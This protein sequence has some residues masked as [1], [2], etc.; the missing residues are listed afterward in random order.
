L[1]RLNVNVNV[2]ISLG[3]V[4]DAI[5]LTREVLM[6]RV[7]LI[8]FAGAPWTTMCYMVQGT[9][10]KSI[11]WKAKLW[12]Y[13]YPNA[14]HKLLRIITDI[15]VEYLIGQV[16]AG[17]QLLEVFE[18]NAGSLTPEL[19]KI[20]SLPYLTQ[21]AR[22]VKSGLV[23]RGLDLVPMIIFPRKAHYALELVA[24]CGYDVI[25]IDWTIDPKQARMRVGG[26]VTIQ[27]N[28]DSGAFF[29]GPDAI[30]TET[31]KM[32]KAFGTQGYIANLGHGMLPSHD[33]AA[34]ATF[35]DAVHDISEKINTSNPTLQL[36]NDMDISLSV[37]E[38]AVAIKRQSQSSGS[39]E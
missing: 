39:K 19:F 18:A 13:K 17:A 25:S 24:N 7:P 21:I 12:L 4:F 31:E 29:G 14:T 15:T 35:V 2:G 3:Y 33:P 11:W 1:E 37:K 10:A 36:E 23:S 34:V 28:L 26:K 6:G 38:L 16:Q 27:G 5:S 30:R 22:R 20:F 9:P 32:V 8:G